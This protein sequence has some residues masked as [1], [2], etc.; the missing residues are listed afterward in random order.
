VAPRDFYTWQDLTLAVQHDRPQPAAELGPLL[1]DLS[2]ER[3]EVGERRPS[4]SLTVHRDDHRLRVPPRAREVFQAEGFRGLACDDEF[5]LTDGVSLLH[6]QVSQG[7]GE[8][9]LVPAFATKPRLLQRTFWAFGLLKLLRPLG[10]YSLHAAGVVHAPDGGLLIVGRSGSG[11]STLAL[12]LLR[13]GWV[14][15][16]DD[17]VLLRRHAEGVK[18]LACRKHVYVHAEAAARYT[19]LPLEAE[20]PDGAGGH[21]RRVGIETA[22]PAQQV[23]GCRP[24]VLLFSRIVSCTHSTLR[25]LDGPTAL[26]HLL[27]HSGPQVFDRQ[28]MQPHLEVLRQLLQQT[29]AYELRAGRDLYE[30]PSM[31]VSLLREAEGAARWPDS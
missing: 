5:Y 19:D 23:A 20:V 17:A 1:H 30:E 22:F 18:A 24:R 2:W 28:T 11:K 4:L 27:A 14:L 25:S 3:T 12:G 15:L 31:L 29:T 26:M 7:R 21:R 8:A 13:Q 6:L 16:S 10:L 9:W